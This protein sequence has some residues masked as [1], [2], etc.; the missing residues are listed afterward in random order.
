MAAN[1]S[2]LVI[3]QVSPPASL[4]ATADVRVGGSTPAENI[5]TFDFDADT[6]EYMD[7][8]CHLEGY[9]GG[10]L[11]LKL[12]WM[13]SSATTGDVVWAAA[14]RRIADDAEDVDGSHSYDYN[15]ATVTT[16]SATGEYDYATITFTDGTDMDSL[17]DGESF[18]L[19]IKRTAD[20]VSDTMAGD[21]ELA[22]IHAIE[23]A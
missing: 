10:G 22:S 11:T 3:D 5:P 20:S 16:A 6:V 4:Y 15:S 23:T 18:V 17:A 19:R 21:A 1:D 9:S 13:A 14:I 8:Y 2:V 12:R 7:F